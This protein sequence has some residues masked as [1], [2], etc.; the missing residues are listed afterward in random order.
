MLTAV[1][2]AVVITALSCVFSRKVIH[3]VLLLV[4]LSVLVAV[5]FLSL[6]AEFLAMNLIVVNVGAIVVLLLFVIMMLKYDKT[7]KLYSLH[8]AVLVMTLL[9]MLYLSYL[10]SESVSA[11]SMPARKIDVIK[12]IAYTVFTKHPFEL[13]VVG[14]ILLTAMI[15]GISLAGRGNKV[16]TQDTMKQITRNPKTSVRLVKVK[17]K[18]GVPW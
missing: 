8:V 4:A 16:K 15:G 5:L 12:E 1:F 9:V 2:I 17:N 7:Y 14:A 6:D 11:F 13:I 10:L 18:A 3:S